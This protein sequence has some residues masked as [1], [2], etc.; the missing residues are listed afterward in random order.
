VLILKHEDFFLLTDP[1][2]D[3][4]PDSRGL[5]LYWGDTRLLSHYE[6]RINDQRPVILRTGVGGSF[7]S[8]LQLTNPAFLRNPS[9]KQDVEIGLRAQSLGILRERL[10]SRGFR[11]RITIQNFTT[12]PERR[13]L[14][15]RL[16]A[17]YADIF[18][19]RGLVRER[20][21]E[22]RPIA[23]MRDRVVFSYRGLD[24]ALRQTHVVLS[25]PAVL[26]AEEPVLEIE[27]EL[28]AGSRRTLEVTIWGEMVDR[29][30]TAGPADLRRRPPPPPLVA[31]DA[32]AGAHRSWQASSAA[33]TA[34]DAFVSRALRRALADLRLL[35]NHG[36][37]HGERY[38]AAGVPWFACLFGRDSLITSLQL[39]AVR[40]QIA[41]ETL[42]LLARW[43]A[44]EVDDWRDAQ[45][46][47]I[48][49]ELRA[50]EMARAGEVPFAPYYGSVDSTPLW[51]ILLGETYRWTGDGALV[52]RLWPHALAALHWI[53]EY[54]DLDG[55]GFVEYE[56]R[57]P[58]GLVNQGWKDSRDANR[59]R[60]GRLAEAPLALVEVQAYVYAARR[61]VAFLARARGEEEF[62]AAQEAAAEALR[63]RFEEAFWMPDSGTYA[64]ALDREK[65]QVDAIASNAGHALWCGIAS[66]E[67][68]A[69][70]ADSLASR[71]MWSGWGIRTLSSAM[72]G[73]NPIGYHI[74][75]VWPHDNA[76][77]AE[78]LVRY[79]YRDQANAI[80]AAM[81][82]ATAYFRDSRLP[83]LFC[84]FSRADSPYPVPYPV[85]CVPQAW[86]AGSLF[87]LV[88]TMLGMQPDAGAKQLDLISPSLPEWLPE[89]RIENMRVGEAVVDLLFRGR[90]GSAGVEILRRTGDVAVVLRI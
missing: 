18:E 47:K 74:G 46:G 87:Q 4:H 14:T 30:R 8:M 55:D 19:V 1:F 67:R 71:E 12:A 38:V 58:R 3:I 28:A 20:R 80:T 68:A 33:I 90:D 49:H 17:D 35:V 11:E 48:L 39:L 5:G 57:S 63:Q 60:D 51:L 23:V 31:E 45:P 24:G 6:L 82:E 21:G 10:L 75:S 64:M 37:G 73:Y 54:G 65:R 27:W 59:S 72:N 66:P 15:L 86:A 77:I 69:R 76:I 50:G 56:R 62:A 16:G 9:D 44:V 29:Q 34:P 43:Q 25:E 13:S 83:E 2:G 22:H 61:N 26:V 79:G 40:P 89:V 32:P 81:L 52:D 53:D 78:G 36:P 85:A 42:E 70:V 84:G 88:R 7:T 41:H